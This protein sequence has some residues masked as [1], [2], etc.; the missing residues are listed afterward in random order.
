MYQGFSLV[1]LE[2]LLNLARLADNRLAE[3]FDH[4]SLMLGHECAT[5]MASACNAHHPRVASADSD[6]LDHLLHFL[7]HLLVLHI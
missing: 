3:Q 2:S 4:R 7:L 6:C 1:G 5:L